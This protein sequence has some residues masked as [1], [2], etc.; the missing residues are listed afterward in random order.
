MTRRLV[1]LESP[2]AGDV[3]RN[4]AYAKACM[5]DSIQRGEAPFASHLLYA[6]AGI[7]DDTNVNEREAG[8]QCGL[9]WAE[10]AEATV[11]YMDLGVS[12]GMK[13]GIDAAKVCGRSVEYRFLYGDG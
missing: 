12:P 3:I 8:I 7:L 5:F 4:V 10:K 6:Q 2:Y 1:F 11:V 13:R 9:A